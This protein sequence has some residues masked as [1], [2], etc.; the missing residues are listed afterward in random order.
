MTLRRALEIYEERTLFSTESELL[1]DLLEGGI[2]TGELV[3][4]FGASN[5]GKTLLGLQVAVSAISRGY[6]CA[7]VDTE[8]QFRPERL[9]SIC[10]AMSLDTSKIL[11][12]LFAIRAETTDRQFDAVRALREDRELI[13]CKLVI[14]DT[15]T[16]NFSLE[17]PGNKMTAKRQSLLAVYLNLLAR[18][19]YFHDRAVLLLNRVAAVP[20]EGQDKEVDIGGDAVGRFATKVVH[21]RR[22]ESTIIASR[23]DE[24]KTNCRLKIDK[25][26][27]R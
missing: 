18:D 17:Y 24:K 19:A 13:S 20:S 9:A 23:V 15:L 2:R 27:L 6:T 25:V 11:E 16:K 14:I 3:E 5:T 8:G 4:V 10:E 12:G 21:L 7:L 22:I 26:G 1:D